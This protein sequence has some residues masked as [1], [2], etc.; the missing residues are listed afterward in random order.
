MLP[1]LGFEIVVLH[2][3]PDPSLPGA[4]AGPAYM[5]AV[6]TDVLPRLRSALA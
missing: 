2:P 4:A 6:A 1:G 5:E 3:V